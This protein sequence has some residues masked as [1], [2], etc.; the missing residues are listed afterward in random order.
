MKP[1]S[2]SSGGRAFQLSCAT[3]S[4]TSLRELSIVTTKPATSTRA[5]RS[6]NCPIRFSVLGDRP[7]RQRLRLQ[8]HQ[9][10]VGDLERRGGR[11]LGARRGVH[12]HHVVALA[13]R[14]EDPDER[15]AVPQEGLHVGGRPQ[16]IASRHRQHGK[17]GQM[18]DQHRFGQADPPLQTGREPIAAAIRA[19]DRQPDRTERVDVHQQGL[20]TSPGQGVAEIEG[21]GRLPDPPLLAG[22]REQRHP[23]CPPRPRIEA[24]VSVKPHVRKRRQILSYVWLSAQDCLDLFFH[25]HGLR[26]PENSSVAEGFDAPG[27]FRAR[28]GSFRAGRASST[29]PPR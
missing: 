29:R 9:H 25:S 11:A 14:V 6:R 10:L 4:R 24:L 5:P 8:R 15:L 18:G 16:R 13:G 26:R 21:D 28:R 20:P 12:H 27:G 7:Q 1:L 19:L 2:T 3:E 23:S 17:L 22:N